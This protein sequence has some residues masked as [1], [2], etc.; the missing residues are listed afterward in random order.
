MRYGR[1]L[2]QCLA[3]AIAL[4]PLPARGQDLPALFKAA[5]AQTSIGYYYEMNQMNARNGSIIAYSTAPG[6]TAAD[7]NGADSPYAAALAE[8]IRQSN[9]PVEIVFR[10]VRARV[11]GET[12]NEQTPWESTSLVSD[13]SFLPR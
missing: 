9:E 10:R 2:L 5:E 8:L 6:K 3:L 13:F 12:Q 4:L 1:W 7:G 11:I